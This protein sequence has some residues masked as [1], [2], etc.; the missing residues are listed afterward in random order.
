MEYYT[1]INRDKIF[2]YNIFEFQKYYPKKSQT[3]KTYFIIPFI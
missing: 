3:Q 1:A 2:I